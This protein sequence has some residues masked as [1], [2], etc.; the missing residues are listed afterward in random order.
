M[1][2]TE[3]SVGFTFSHKKT[4]KQATLLNIILKKDCQAYSNT[5]FWKKKIC[6]VYSKSYVVYEEQTDI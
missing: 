1:N 2:Y 5:Y 6:N 4:N 3:K